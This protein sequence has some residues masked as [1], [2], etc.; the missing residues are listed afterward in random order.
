M[1][2][3]FIGDL[4]GCADELEDLLGALRYDPSLHELHFVG[5][6]V[7][8]GPASRRAL[9]RVIELGADTVLGNHDLHLLAVAGGTRSP[10]D[11]DTLDDILSAPDREQLLAWVRRQPLVREWNDLILVHAGL[12]PAW[13][14]PGAV[15]LPLQRRIAAGEIPFDDP[16]LKFLTKVRYCDPGGTEMSS[17]GG[18]GQAPWDDFYRGSKMVVCGHWA[19]RGLVQRERLRSIDTGCVWGGRLTAW[20][21]EEDRLVSVP[22]RAVYRHPE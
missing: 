20:I 8:R 12:N 16:D 4:Q 21:A 10:H 11:D 5:D 3:V 13:K 7:N 19:M 18:P 17:E 15:A 2:R 1:Q 6:L 9:R 22:A 14:D